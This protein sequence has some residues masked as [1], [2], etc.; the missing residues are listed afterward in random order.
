MIK[1]FDFDVFRLGEIGIDTK[2]SF[3]IY[4]AV[5]LDNLEN[6]TI[7]FCKELNLNKISLLNLLSECIIILPKVIDENFKKYILNLQEKNIIIQTKNPRLEF[8]RILGF[9]VDYKNIEFGKNLIIGENVVVGKNVKFGNNVVVGNNVNINDN[10]IIMDGVILKNNIILK[11]DVIIRENA[12]IGGWGFGFERDEENIPIRLPHIGGVIIEKNVEIGALASVAS[13]TMLPTIIGKNT[14]IDDRTIIAHNCNIGE[15]CIITG[16]VSIC[17]SVKVGNNVWIGPNSTIKDG[18][19]VGNNAIIGIGSVVKRNVL[20][21]STV[22]GNPAETIEKIA[23]N[24]IDY[25]ELK[26]KI[27]K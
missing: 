24:R 17:G 12:V 25:I 11:E 16:N 18:L 23:K 20:D 22:M 15:N 7:C 4:D 2:F 21:N 26:N 10:C 19:S 1:K 8:A 3:H 5:T 9:I 13:G 14:K 27:F 6:N